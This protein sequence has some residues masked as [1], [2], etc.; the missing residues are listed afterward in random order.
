MEN[1][2]EKLV[3]MYE[4][5]RLGGSIKPIKVTFKEPTVLT[6]FCGRV[7]TNKVYDKDGDLVSYSLARKPK[8]EYTL[9]L[10]KGANGEICLSNKGSR[11]KS[12]YSHYILFKDSEIESIEF[13]EKS[14]KKNVDWDL[15][16][17]DYILNNTHD[18]MWD[19]LK[20]SLRDNNFREKYLIKE[21]SGGRIKTVSIK[22]VFPK[23][24]CENIKKAIEEKHNFRYSMNGVRRDKSV[25][26]KICEDGILRGWYSSEYSGTGNGAYYLLINPY[27]A[28]FAEFD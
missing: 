16:N 19:D 12:V 24:V 10:Y 13:F 1:L 7:K 25:E 8:K 18:N 11:V 2:Y 4:T 20:D 6:P 22:S 15:K 27:T 23:W 17:R 28:I 5:Q 14:S 21:N 9:Y 3:E 26:I